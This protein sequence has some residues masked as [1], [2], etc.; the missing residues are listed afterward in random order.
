MPLDTPPDDVPPA[1]VG[2]LTEHAQ[3]FMGTL[4]DLAQ[5]GMLEVRED[6]GSWGAKKFNLEL[7]NS[8][9]SLRPHEQGLLDALLK[10]GETAVE[11]SAIPAR[12]ASKHKAGGIA[13]SRR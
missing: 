13:L 11:M 5:R 10:P 7:K 6:K 12:L 8:A 2:K 4:F 1:L 3:G 9:A